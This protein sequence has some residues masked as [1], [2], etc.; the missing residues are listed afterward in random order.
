VPRPR[1]IKIG[2]FR[3]AVEYTD[4]PTSIIVAN[5]DAGRCIHDSCKIIINSTMHPAMV[6][7]S[8]FHEMLHAVTNTTGVASALGD[9]KEEATVTTLSATLLDVLRRNPGLV[10]YLT[11]SE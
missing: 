10:R 4:S 1:H 9:E 5:D 3:Y 6:R 11:E 2:P 8:V 7:E